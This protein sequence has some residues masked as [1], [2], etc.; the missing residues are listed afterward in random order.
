[1]RSALPLAFMR[2]TL[3]PRPARTAASCRTA[4]AEERR[5]AV[6]DATGVRPQDTR[7]QPGA[8][9]APRG[10]QAGWATWTK[11]SCCRCS[12]AQRAALRFP[13]ASGGTPWR[14]RIPAAALRRIPAASPRAKPPRYASLRRSAIT[15]LISRQRVSATVLKVRARKCRPLRVRIPKE[16]R[17]VPIFGSWIAGHFRTKQNN[18][19][20]DSGA[21]RKMM[22]VCRR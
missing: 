3:G 16:H 2:A 17:R 15:P 1:M 7:Q 11:R 10:R 6:Q 21:C 19:K 18:P 4:L 8:E 12:G 14:C 22:A 13:T 5:Q 9:R 20:S